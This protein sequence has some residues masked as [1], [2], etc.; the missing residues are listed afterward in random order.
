MLVPLLVRER[1]TTEPARKLPTG[2]RAREIAADLSRVFS[3][4]SPLVVAI[5][6]IVINISAGMLGGVGANLLVGELHWSYESYAELAGGFVLVVGCAC[7]G[8]AGLLA[9]RL[10]KRRIAA[11]ACCALA[12]GWIL[13][14]AARGWGW[15]ESH[16]YVYV[17]SMFET[18]MQATLSVTLI[19]LSMDLSWPKVAASQFTAYMALLNFSTTLGFLFAARAS[20]WWTYQGIYLV[21]AGMQL[22]AAVLLFAIDPTQTRRELHAIEG[23]SVNR[24]GL[25]GLIALVVFLA[26]MTAYVTYTT[27]KRLG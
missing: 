16:T 1:A 11:L 2:A 3:L 14:A 19:A 27:I 6:L 8:S 22:G 21:A 17:S 4:R 12:A 13:F 20:T 25:L 15:W 23:T 7:A 10:G 24:K 26:L 9:D 18:A 5:L